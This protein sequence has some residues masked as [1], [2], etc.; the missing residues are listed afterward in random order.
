MGWKEFISSKQFEIF[1]NL[2]L[3]A[4]AISSMI[5]CIKAYG[6][7]RSASAD[8][9]GIAKNWNT[10]PLM[11]VEVTSNQSCPDG[12]ESMPIIDFEGLREGP[13]GC[14]SNAYYDGEPYYSSLSNCITNQTRAGCVQDPGLDGITLDMFLGRRTCFKRGGE[15][16]VESYYPWERRPIPEEGG[17][18]CSNGYKVCGS[19]TY[20]ANKAICWPEDLNCPI[21]SLSSNGTSNSSK[22]DIMNDFMES[23]N[24]TLDVTENYNNNQWLFQGHKQLDLLPVVDF[25]IA[26]TRNRQ[27]VLGPCYWDYQDQEHYNGKAYWKTSAQIDMNHPKKACEKYDTR[28]KNF[29]VQKESELLLENFASVSAC[30][31]KNMSKNHD[32]YL[33]GTECQGSDC[34]I[35]QSLDCSSSDSICKGIKYQS[36]CG[37]YQMIARMAE[38]AGTSIGMFFRSQIEWK[39]DCASSELQVKDAVGPVQATVNAQFALMI[40]NVIT[41]SIV[42]ILIP[43]MLIYNIV[44]NDVPCVPGEGEGE[45]KIIKAMKGSFSHVLRSIKMIPLIITIVLISKIMEYFKMLSDEACSDNI[46]NFTITFLA[47][48]LPAVMSENIVTLACDIV[49]ILLTAVSAISEKAKGSENKV[50]PGGEVELTSDNILRE[51]YNGLTQEQKTW[52]QNQMML[53]DPAA[54]TYPEIQQLRI[55][56][57]IYDNQMAMMTNS[58]PMIIQE[59]IGK[60][61]KSMIV[62]VPEDANPGEILTVKS[63]EGIDVSYTVPPN[64]PGNALSIDYY[65]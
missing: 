21:T 10:K 16:A 53:T 32:Y 36:K 7:L 17:A 44:Y 11:Y 62:K 56:V 22:F 19:G 48:T 1:V 52:L 9:A 30:S 26:F 43:L 18:S 59:M 65:V 12:W 13:C 60:E 2:M 14:P 64:G 8:F 39:V 25:K 58:N 3:I 55:M 33:D 24:Y 31:G 35:S 28:F 41:N 23:K 63:L 37:K 40:I 57:Q 6:L 4:M 20:E 46:T 29:V 61:K 51:K 49:T 15:A 50:H 45:K 54:L 38:N 42:G 27:E 5:S 47:T 34:V